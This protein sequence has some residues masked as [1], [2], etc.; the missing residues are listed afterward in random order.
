MVDL[1]SSEH[2]RRM[3]DYP[4][5]VM[6]PGKDQLLTLLLKAEKDEEFLSS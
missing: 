4:E 5:T 1:I 2:L 6:Q 3:T